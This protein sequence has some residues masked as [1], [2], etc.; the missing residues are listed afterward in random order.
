[1]YFGRSFEWF[2][3]EHCSLN[4]RRDTSKRKVHCPIGRCNKLYTLIIGERLEQACFCKKHREDLSKGFRTVYKK[5]VLAPILALMSNREV[6]AYS[7]QCELRARESWLAVMVCY[8]GVYSFW[9]YFGRSFEWFLPE[10]CSLNIRRDT[11]K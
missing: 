7:K 3:P 5:V 1:M 8:W 4:I 10:H 11:S 2:L 6:S 9:M